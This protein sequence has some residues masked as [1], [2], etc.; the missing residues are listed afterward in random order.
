[1]PSGVPEP[2]CSDNAALIHPIF[3]IPEQYF[4]TGM[5]VAVS[6]VMIQSNAIIVAHIPEPVAHPR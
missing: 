3:E 4:R 5:A 1:M 6:L 2:I